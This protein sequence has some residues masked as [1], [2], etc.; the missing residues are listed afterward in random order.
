MDHEEE[1]RELL[2]TQLQSN[3]RDAL[4]EVDLIA[5]VGMILW[6]S[7]IADCAQ[8][9][10]M[11]QFQ[12]QLADSAEQDERERCRNGPDQQSSSSSNRSLAQAYGIDIILFTTRLTVGSRSCGAQGHQRDQ[13]LQGRRPTHD[14]VP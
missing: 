2:I 4:D 6:T 13:D 10:S 14:E 1:T 3:A 11:M 7:W 9:M 12:D 8:E 5:Q